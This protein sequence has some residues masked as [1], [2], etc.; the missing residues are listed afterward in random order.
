MIK[1]TRWASCVIKRYHFEDAVA[2]GRIP[3][4]MIQMK[5]A[6]NK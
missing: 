1:S 4:E 3:L 2:N 5:Q 6:M